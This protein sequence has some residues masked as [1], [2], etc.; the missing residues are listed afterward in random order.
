MRNTIQLQ[1]RHGPSRGGGTEGALYIT[2]S[3][4]NPNILGVNRNDKGR[5]VNA[6][7][8]NP[9]NRWNRENGFVFLVPQL[10]S[11]LSCYGRRVLLWPYEA[12]AE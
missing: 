1:D 10:S 2:D 4:G 8:G 6:Y 9:D 7:N 12:L 11:F 3:N 5:W